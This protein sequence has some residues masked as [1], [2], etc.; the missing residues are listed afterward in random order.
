M[1]SVASEV[2]L[3][4]LRNMEK[5]YRNYSDWNTRRKRG[6]ERGRGNKGIA[7]LIGKEGGS[8]TISLKRRHFCSFEKLRGLTDKGEMRKMCRVRNQ[9]EP[10]L[11]YERTRFASVDRMQ[12]GTASVKHRVGRAKNRWEMQRQVG[13]LGV[14]LS[15][16]YRFYSPVMRRVLIALAMVRQ[17]DI[18]D[19]KQT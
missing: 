14:I 9:H 8:N 15:R 11:R 19:E 4:Q 2:H 6:E 12:I 1:P 10:R 7:R 13:G 3:T 16:E 17:A 5:F 18:K